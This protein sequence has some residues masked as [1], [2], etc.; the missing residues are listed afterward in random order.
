MGAAASV[1]SQAKEMFTFKVNV[2]EAARYYPKD[3]EDN[4]SELDDDEDDEEDEEDDEDIQMAN[5]MADDAKEMKIRLYKA[6]Y[7]P[8]HPATWENGVAPSAL[9]MQHLTPGQVRKLGRPL[10]PEHWRRICT[11]SWTGVHNEE[12]H[13]YA[14]AWDMNGKEPFDELVRV[15]YGEGAYRRDMWLDSLMTKYGPLYLPHRDRLAAAQNSSFEA[16]ATFKASKTVREV[17]GKLKTENHKS[18]QELDKFEEIIV[19]PPI[20]Q[21]GIHGGV[22]INQKRMQDFPA[23][24]MHAH[25]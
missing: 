22:S 13:Q 14:S 16:G 5:K 2:R 21:A 10:D 25:G 7:P 4:E 9:P 8:G 23:G 18:G 15:G 6:T 3:D 24:G 11:G 20:K 19:L 1:A 17:G 12:W